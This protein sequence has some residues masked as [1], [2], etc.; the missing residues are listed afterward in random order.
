MHFSAVRP[1]IGYGHGTVFFADKYWSDM[2]SA[3]ALGKPF[4]T[5]ADGTALRSLVCADDLGII[6]T[7]MIKAESSPHPA[8]NIGGPPQSLLDLA[9]VVKKYI[10]DAKISFGKKAPPAEPGK[11]GLPW[12]VSG[13]LVKND[14]G[15]QCMPIER[16]VL[17]HINDARLEAGLPPIKG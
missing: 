3:A 15:F 7:L 9:K 5:E 16:A 12:K 4:S 11:A 14:F 13:A 1:T 2:P 6:T 17:I 8:Y 10:P